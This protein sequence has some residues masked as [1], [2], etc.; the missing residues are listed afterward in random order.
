MGTG[1][2]ERLGVIAN[3][4]AGRREAMRFRIA[5]A[6]LFVVFALGAASASAAAAERAFPEYYRCTKTAKVGKTYTSEYTEKAC[7]TKASP[8][9]TGRY[10]RQAV[11]SGTFEATGKGVTLIT[12]STIGVAESVACKLGVS[13]GELL[14]GGVYAADKLT[15]EGCIGNGEKKTNPCGNVGPEAIEAKPLFSTLVWLNGGETEAGILLEGEGE[16][17]AKFKCGAEQIDLEGYL[18]G[19]IENTKKGHTITFS[20]NASKEQARMSIWVFGG[21][22]VSL[23]LYTQASAGESESTLEAVETQSGTNVY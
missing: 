22:I 12:H 14:A 8:A 20:L 15:L 16:Q 6:C 21:E 23:H 5:G 7:K 11:G 9:N 17:I 13:R 10:E 3:G 18:V 2:R 1:T 19:A 4:A